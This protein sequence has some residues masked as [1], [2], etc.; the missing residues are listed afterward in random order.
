VRSGVCQKAAFKNIQV[1]KRRQRHQGK[2]QIDM[3]RFRMDATSTI[4]GLT[5]RMPHWRN[6]SHLWWQQWEL[7]WECQSSFEE[8]SF[9][10][11]LVSFDCVGTR[12][13]DATYYMVSAGLDECDQSSTTYE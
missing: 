6:E 9:A 11:G 2:L 3:T 4:G 5:V 7:G 13:P 12:A 10:V 8:A 1:W